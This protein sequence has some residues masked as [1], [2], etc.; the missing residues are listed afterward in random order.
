MLA[1]LPAF[2]L[3]LAFAQ[4]SSVELMWEAPLDVQTIMVKAPAVFMDCP[5][6]LG[7]GFTGSAC[8]MSDAS[9]PRIEASIDASMAT[10]NAAKIADWE[11]GAGGISKGWVTQDGLTYLVALWNTGGTIGDAPAIEVV[12]VWDKG[13]GP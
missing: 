13:S 3:S 5:A 12:I 11:L 9:V 1:A 4:N 2:G 10:L 6:G 8:G 7:D